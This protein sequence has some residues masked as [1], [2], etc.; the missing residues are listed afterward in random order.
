MQNGAPFRLLL[1]SEVVAR[2]RR[3]EQK[4]ADYTRSAP[5]QLGQRQS[6][7]ETHIALPIPDSRGSRDYM[8]W[9]HALPVARAAG[10]SMLQSNKEVSRQ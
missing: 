3:W 7:P 2:D 10:I 5:L 4:L 1:R 6:E 8:V 9:F